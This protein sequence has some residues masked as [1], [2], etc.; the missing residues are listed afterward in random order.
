MRDF[1]PHGAETEEQVLGAPLV[2]EPAVKMVAE[3]SGL[4]TAD[5]YLDRH[6]VLFEALVDL[7]RSGKPIDT[8]MVK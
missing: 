8:L 4:E 2:Y 5:F 3:D 7:H 1:P 6:R